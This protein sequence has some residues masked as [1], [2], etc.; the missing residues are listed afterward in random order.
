MKLV[1]VSSTLESFIHIF[2]DCVLVFDLCRA[3]AVVWE[4]VSVVLS[5]TDRSVETTRIFC[6]YW[7]EAKST[8]KDRPSLS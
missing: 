1:F 2:N 5:L 6:C 7:S 3:L 4:P 8:G